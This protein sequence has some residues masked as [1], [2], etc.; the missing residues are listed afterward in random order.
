MNPNS[1]TARNVSATTGAISCEE[2]NHICGTATSGRPSTMARSSPIRRTRTDAISPENRQVQMARPNS[3]PGT[4][5]DS[6]TGSGG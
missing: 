5:I 2:T 3:P 6:S 4:M 1:A